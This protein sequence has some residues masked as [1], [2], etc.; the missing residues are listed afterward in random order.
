MYKRTALFLLSLS[1]LAACQSPRAY[2]P[3][4][5]LNPALRAQN[6]FQTRNADW[7]AQLSPELQAY[8]APARV[9]KAE[10]CLKP[11]TNS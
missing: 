2:A 1:A 11:F 3:N 9:Y 5:N 7:F 8:Y 4:A 6:Q 10:S